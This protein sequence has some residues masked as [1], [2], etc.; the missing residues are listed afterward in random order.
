MAKLNLETSI[1]L[2]GNVLARG[3]QAGKSQ[4]VAERVYERLTA[5]RTALREAEVT[6][7]RIVAEI[8]ARHG[9]VNE[10]NAA[11][12]AALQG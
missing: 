9:F 4:P 7:D 3:A 6:C 11:I 2:L 10:I 8:E 12:E 1:L 5:A